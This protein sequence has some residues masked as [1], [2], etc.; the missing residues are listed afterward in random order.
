MLIT[1]DEF[2]HLT[3]LVSLGL[4]STL[5]F[6]NLLFLLKGMNLSS[7]NTKNLSLLLN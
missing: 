5:N 1:Q 6:L 2:T 3:H 4:S 7:I